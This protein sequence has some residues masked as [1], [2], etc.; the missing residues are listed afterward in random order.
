MKF[1][2]AQ[3]DEPY[4]LWQLQV[5]LTNFARLG[6][7]DDLI[8]LLGVRDKPSRTAEY[9]KARTSAQVHFIPDTRLQRHYP[10]S[11]QFHLYAKFFADHKI[12]EPYMLIDTDVVFDSMPHFHRMIEDDLIYMS[13]T[14]SYLGFNYLASKGIEQLESL[15]AIVGIDAHTIERNDKGAGGAQTIMKGF[16]DPLFWQKVERDALSLYD[17]MAKSES[18]WKG[19]GYPIQKWTAGMWSFLW[20]LWGAGAQTRVTSD[21][22]F[23]WGSDPISKMKP[24]VHMAGVTPDMSSTHFFKGGYINRHPHQDDLLR[25][26]DQPQSIADYYVCKILDSKKDWNEVRIST[27]R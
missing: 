24:I 4:F 6:I 20:N 1:L 16:E 10:P 22:D 18:Q 25:C 17:T 2:S 8:V 13:D 19:E 5:Q 12:G 3:P 9:I 21:L 23:C 14:N 7:E 27:T 26:L 15:A 11:V